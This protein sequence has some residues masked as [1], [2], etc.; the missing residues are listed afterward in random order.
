MHFCVVSAL[1][2]PLPRS[3]YDAHRSAGQLR[4]VLPTRLAPLSSIIASIGA[5]HD[6]ARCAV[7]S[8]STYSRRLIKRL[9]LGA[10]G[11]AVAFWLFWSIDH[12]TLR[13]TEQVQL[14]GGE[15]VLVKVRLKSS[16]LMP[17]GG[18]GSSFTEEA[19]YEIL[20]Q[21]PPV[22][23]WKDKRD[24]VLL[25]RDP[26]TRE[27]VLVATA[28]YREVWKA[29][30]RP[31]NPYWMFRLRNGVWREE[32]MEDFVFGRPTNLVQHPDLADQVEGAVTLDQKAYWLEHEGLQRSY[33]RVEKHY[34]F[35]RD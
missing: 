3:R 25:W 27:L 15:V 26:N 23:V 33:S 17:I 11:L 14:E 31:R 30:D 28:G 12:A 34:V 16:Y 6:N 22:P 35:G 24:P 13:W 1:V 8:G 7:S 2:L 4:S 9:V 20:G 32:P 5:A 29:H 21:N 10:A 19:R 18:P